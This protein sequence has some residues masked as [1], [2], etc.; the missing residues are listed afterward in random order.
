PEFEVHTHGRLPVAAAFFRSFGIVELIDRAVPSEM[1]VGVGTHVLAMVLDCL[2]GRS[3][4]QQV[5]CTFED[6]D[7]ELLFGNEVSANQFNDDALGRAL[8]RLQAAGVGSL[9][10]AVAMQVC[11][12]MQIP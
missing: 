12:Q 7:T 8:D 11:R 2:S 10:S 5:E 9:F 4:L 1:G 6:V 3:P